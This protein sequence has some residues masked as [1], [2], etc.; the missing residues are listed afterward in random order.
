MHQFSFDFGDPIFDLAGWRVGLQVITFENTY[1]LDPQR[2]R[3]QEDGGRWTLESSGLTSA[4][5]QRKHRGRAW[6]TAAPTAVGLEF[7]AGAE[8]EKRIRC[9]KLILRGLPTGNLVGRRWESGPVP[10]AGTVLRYPFDASA[11]LALHTP[12]VFLSDP[13]G[14][15]LYFQSLDERVRCKRFAIFPAAKGLSME[16][17]HEEAGHEMGKSV[18]VPP[19]RVGRCTDPESIVEEHLRLLERAHGLQPWETR[20]DVPPWARDISMVV[21]IH[22]M[23]WTGRVFNTY[24]DVLRTLQ[25]VCQRIEGRRVLA[26]LPGWEG[27]Y[28]WQYADYRPEPRL[29]GADGFR[30]LAEGAQRLGVSLMPMFGAN[31][32]NTGLPRFRRWG[33]PSLLRSAGGLV[34]QGNKPDWDTSRA[35]DPGWQAWLNPGAPAWRERLLAQVSDLVAEYGLPAVFFDT[36]HF[37]ENDPQYPVYEGLVA[38]RDSLKR[39]FPDLLVAG[40]GWYDA[41]GAVTP[42]SQ[43]GATAQWHQV[44]SR[45]CRTF[46]HLMWGDPSRASTGVHEAGRTGFGLVPNERHWWPTVTIVDGTL[47]RAPDKVEQVIEQAREY[48]RR[49]LE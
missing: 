14:G 32:A 40:E 30:K 4:G 17:I 5:G 36:H 47:E 41:L 19:W 39:R 15:L 1:G 29:G 28:Y 13:D 27:R 26:F 16:L 24:E 21:S 48:A 11:P 18:A 9:L 42:V 46:G 6:L 12:L 45:Y 25:W 49:Y 10:P 31:C 3:L 44:F 2:T 33:E 43:V 38:L 37:W 7:A 23:H 20:P 34:L 35:N 22:G 8:H